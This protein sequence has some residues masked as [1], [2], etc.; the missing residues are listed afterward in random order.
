M[1]R[2]EFLS[3]ENKILRERLKITEELL[4]RTRKTIGHLRDG[5]KIYTPDNLGEY[6]ERCDNEE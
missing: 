1:S 6:R 2:V 3:R 4:T 5:V